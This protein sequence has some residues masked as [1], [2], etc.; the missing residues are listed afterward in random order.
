MLLIQ[1]NHNGRA[2]IVTVA[3]IDAANYKTHKSS[4]QQILKGAVPFK[5]LMDT[6]ATKTMIAPR[7]VS[8]LNLQLV[9]RLDFSGLGGLSRRNGYLFHVAFY[10]L[11]PTRDT[12]VSK[13][14]IMRRA[15]N[16]GELS[17]EDTFDVLLGMD[18]LTTGNLHID[19]D[20]TFRFM[21]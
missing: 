3:I 7:V 10:E 13:I 6:G 2:A 14:Q 8:R 17:Q 15:I 4:D 21:F 18:V 9:N 19:R 11:P 1:G 16:G 12:E 5:A 20:G